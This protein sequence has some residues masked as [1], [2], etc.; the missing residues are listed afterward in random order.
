MSR[1]TCSSV[2]GALLFAIVLA[3]FPTVTAWPSSPQWGNTSQEIIGGVC[4]DHY[5][6]PA[7][8]IECIRDDIN[9]TRL[10][11]PYLRVH[12]RTSI[13]NWLNYTTPSQSA[14]PDYPAALTIDVQAFQADDYTDAT[15]SVTLQDSTA[16]DMVDKLVGIAI[17]GVPIYT[18]LGVGGYDVLQPSGSYAD[19]A[20][21]AV[22]ECGGTYGDTPHGRRYHY[23]TVRASLSLPL[24]LPL[25]LSLTHTNTHTHTHTH[26]SSEQIP[27][28]VI[29]PLPAG[30]M[31][32][33]D[34]WGTQLD[35]SAFNEVYPWWVSNPQSS[36]NSATSLVSMTDNHEKRQRYVDD[37]HELLDNFYQTPAEKARQLVGWTV[38]GHPIYSPFNSRGL[39]QT[40]LDNC[41]GKF[42]GVGEYAYYASPVFP[43]IVGCVGPGTYS[44]EE[45]S[46]Y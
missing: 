39:L 29:A 45:E 44:L 27:S 9:G 1:Q 35:V 5:F 6:H 36:A 32:D 22:D 21:L 14:S 23:R 19:V 28:C 37:S 24:S 38:E 2:Q 13:D 46:T 33:E 43:Y 30:H 41:N 20:P 34:Q 42:D 26:T 4:P 7:V 3:T 12:A 40:N 16:A 11:A 17:D 10:F 25:P 8:H 18:A 31:W 15:Q